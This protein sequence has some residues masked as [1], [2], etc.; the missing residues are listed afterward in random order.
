MPGRG[1][2]SPCIWGDRI[3]L[4]TAD[5][6]AELQYMLCYDRATGEMLWQSEVHRGGFMHKHRKNSHAS[7]T[8]ACDGRSVYITFM[9]QGG[10]WLTALGMD[11]RIVWQTMAGP[12]TPEHGYGAS[13]GNTLSD[14]GNERSAMIAPNTAPATMPDGPRI[15]PNTYPAQKDDRMRNRPF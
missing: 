6:G 10:I 11:G 5:E 2:G 14:L 4:P 12:F 15:E 3:F 7:S 1:H 8:A 9:V 13:P